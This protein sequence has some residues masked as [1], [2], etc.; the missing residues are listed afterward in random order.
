[1]GRGNLVFQYPE[2]GFWIHNFLF[3]RNTNKMGWGDLMFG[4]IDPKKLSVETTKGG[5]LIFR[6]TINDKKKAELAAGKIHLARTGSPLE[7]WEIKHNAN[8]GAILK[9]TKK[10]SSKITIGEITKKFEQ[11][12]S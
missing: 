1:M 3:S 11:M 7:E 10:T 6:Y 12:I 2:Y 8:D 9:M 5:N 4:E